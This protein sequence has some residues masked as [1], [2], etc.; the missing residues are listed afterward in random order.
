MEKSAVRLFLYFLLTLVK[1]GEL[2]VWKLSRSA[3][4]YKKW[5]VRK[6][7]WRRGLVFRPATHLG[8]AGLA[9]LAIVG[10]TIFGPLPSLAAQIQSQTEVVAP[11]TLAETAV[12]Q[13]RPR[14]A[15]IEYTVN[16]G[17]TL[18]AIAT[19]EKV[20]VDT[21]KWANNLDSDTI[22]PGQKLLVPPVTGVVH[23]VAKGETLA[24]LADQHGV[25][26]ADIMNFPFNDIP[27]NQALEEGQ[28]VV[29]PNG[30]PKDI[31]HPAPKAPAYLASSR[32]SYVN[33]SPGS[34]LNGYP[35]GQCTYYVATRRHIPWMD[36][37]GG[38]YRDA[39]AMGVSVGRAPRAGAIMVSYEGSAYGHV[40][41]VER[42]NRDGSWV[43]S[44]MNFWG[45]SGGGWG[46]VDSRTVT[47][48][49]VF[50][51]GFIY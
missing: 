1:Y 34:W 18:G 22:N 7:L 46:R 14:A 20:S 32:T 45:I 48:G 43:V 40:S 44:E 21:L 16:D 4:F 15:T 42:V 36:N 47:P 11:Q 25:Q 26:V 33:Y 51:V 50:V 39:I 5:T 6:L 19:K 9:L 3:T 8:V 41:Y 12:P 31:V 17:E 38:W 35:F 37:A 2:K 27:D 30:R 28:I 23:V 13:D 49:S 29:V 24:S 10:G